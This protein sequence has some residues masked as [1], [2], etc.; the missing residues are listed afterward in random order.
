[1]PPTSFG[2]PKFAQARILV[3]DG[4]KDLFTK[5][6]LR[7]PRVF[8][9]VERGYKRAA[10]IGLKAIASQITSSG[11][12]GYGFMRKSLTS[13]IVVKPRARKHQILLTFGTQAWYDILVHEGLGRHGGSRKV[14][15]QYKPTPAQI[16]IIEP[17]VEDRLADKQSWNK[18]PGY[19]RPFLTI[20]LLNAKSAMN[21]SIADGVKKGMGVSTRAKGIPKYDL[22][23]LLN[24]GSV[25]IK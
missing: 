4:F 20:G 7:Q 21:I 23:K 13:T 2:S 14:P 15:Y 3:D 6:P 24:A 11:A 5:N 12:V 10:V 22:V 18:S 8:R 1:M 25:R 9:E 17:S 19:P 16:A